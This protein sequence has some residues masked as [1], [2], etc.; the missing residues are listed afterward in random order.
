MPFS[1][2]KNIAC[3]MPTTLV[4]LSTTTEQLHSD[5]TKYI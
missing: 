2:K 5:C 3:M 4:I 1:L